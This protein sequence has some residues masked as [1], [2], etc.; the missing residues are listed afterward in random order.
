MIGPPPAVK[1]DAAGICSVGLTIS[2]ASTRN[3]IV[4]IF[5]NELR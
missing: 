4:P 1:A 5:M 2:T 3:A